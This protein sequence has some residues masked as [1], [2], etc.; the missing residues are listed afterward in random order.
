MTDFYL[1]TGFLGAGKTTFLADFLPRFNDKNLKI[2]INEFGNTGVD[3]S[4]LSG[5]NAELD[6]I[7]GG[8]IFCSCKLDRFETAMNSCLETKPDVIVVE[9][10][11][12][13]DPTNIKKVLS[14]YEKKNLLSYKGCICLVDAVRFH[15]VFSTARVVK[16]QLAVA[17]LLLVNKT[18]LV[19][20]LQLEELENNIKEN[21]PC[22]NIVRTK[23][24]KT[25]YDFE[26]LVNISVDNFDE[27]AYNPDITTQKATVEIEPSMTRYE[28]E[29]FVG[30]FAEDTARIKG[31][32]NLNEC[33][34]V[35]LD[36][37]GA[38]INLVNIS[39]KK[40]I[41]FGIN[42][43][44]TKGQPL[45]KALKLAVSLYS[46]KTKVKFG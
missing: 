17:D 40:N 15:K 25:N 34:V 18:D 3:A 30:L 43:M 21:F 46:E 26:N 2:I 13:S 4:L 45:R 37:V 27:N 7:C 24:G 10:S 12:L 38:M 14:N 29:R 39:E 22:A 28:L 23:F 9:A 1:V 19:S 31:Y 36:C 41:D 16:K 33:G 6:E 44:A 32:V 35:L 11:G 20:S 5:I 8:S 42:V